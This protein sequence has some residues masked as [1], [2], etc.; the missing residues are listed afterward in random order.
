[1]K[2]LLRK[3][4]PLCV[5]IFGVSYLTAQQ[6]DVE[7]GMRVSGLTDTVAYDSVMVLGSAG[8]VGKQAVSDL[9]ALRIVGDT[10]FVGP[11]QFVIL[12]ADGDSDP[13]NELQSWSTLPGI[14]V[15][16][17]I[18]ATDDF[19]GSYSD[20]TDI[21]PDMADGDQVDDADADPTNEL[22][23]WST[24]PGIPAGIDI[25]ATDDFSG[26]F[27][28]LSDV[29]ADIADGDQ[30]DDADADATNELQVL[31]ID[32]DTLRLSDGGFAVLQG[33]SRLE[34]LLDVYEQQNNVQARLDLGETPLQI[35]N[36]GMPI[37]SLYGKSYEGGMIFYLDTTDGTGLVAT[38]SD[39]GTAD[40]GCVATDLPS[41][42]NSGSGTGPG[43]EIGD[44]ATNTVGIL[45]D[46]ASRPIAASLAD[47]VGAGWYLPSI[48]ELDLMHDNLHALGMGGFSTS[49]SYSSSTEVASSDYWEK[50][51]QFDIDIQQFK[52]NSNLIRAAKQ[53]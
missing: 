31:S 32:G 37:D 26:S 23:S 2:S 3:F 19:S 17:D 51:F 35:V 6:L 7:G 47:A 50:N 44:G 52:G 33:L 12:P 9:I 40:W 36:S 27:N 46:C 10:I 43:A 1:M 13:L 24:L 25:D 5:I 41:V 53:F 49:D 15:D 16:I 8:L 11:D 39:Q 34:L 18:D 21:P 22:Q 38:M 48:K 29:P 4:L 20:L 42:P 28:D 45:G 14:P 30:V